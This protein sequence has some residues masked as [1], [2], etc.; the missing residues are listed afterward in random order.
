MRATGCLQSWCWLP[1]LVA[2]ATTAVAAPYEPPGAVHRVETLLMEWRDTARDRVVPVKIYLPADAAGGRPVILFS[3][4]LGGSREHYE[5]LG[6]HWA[7]AGMV[8]VHLQH[9]GSDE[10]IWKGVSLPRRMAVLRQAAADPRNAMER[11]RDVGFAIDQLG[12]LNGAEGRLKGRLDLD[13]IGV[14]GHSFGG[15]TAMAIAGQNYTRGKS[16]DGR[17]ARVKAVIQM[18]A[19][20]PKQRVR[21][22]AYDNVVLPVFHMTGTDDESPVN[23]TTAAERRVPFD[24]TRGEACLLIFKGGDHAVFSGRRRLSRTAARRDEAFHRHILRSSTAYWDAHLNG[25][26]AAKEWLLG[27]GFAGELGGD[28]T[29]EVRRER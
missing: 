23:A 27:G 7:A 22:Y 8:S 9:A 29:F 20:V 14:A 18:S 28:G 4:G 15:Y 12:R 11:P 24:R 21:E 6:R 13:R 25:K 16:G 3:H 2:L 17:D 5:Y 26:T 1:V 10:A 19:P